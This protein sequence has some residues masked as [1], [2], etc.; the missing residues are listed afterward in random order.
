MTAPRRPCSRCGTTKPPGRGRRF[1]DDCDA[2][3]AV[4]APARAREHG[5]RRVE[6]NRAK[7]EREGTGRVYRTKN[8]PEGQAWC[9]RCQQ[10]LLIA[11][12]PTSTSRKN[13]LAPYCR[14]CYSEFLHARRLRQEFDMTPDEY[15]ELL[16]A[17]DG[18][19]AICMAMP[20]TRRLAVDHDHK[21]GEVRGLLCTRCNHKVLGAARENPSILRRAAEY[22]ERTL[23]REPVASPTSKF[24]QEVERF[25]DEHMG[26]TAGIE[27]EFKARFNASDF[28]VWTGDLE[29]RAILTGRYRWALFTRH[30]GRSV[31]EAYVTL[32]LWAFAELVGETP[33]TRAVA[34]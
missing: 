12:F 33:D 4:E 15:A 3:L 8:A 11:D 2:I 26:T 1:C 13:G 9:S 18:R 31:R 7:R 30:R 17:Q 22:L 32:P 16:A 34:S 21:T 5:K 10:Y 25:I 6:R 28:E 14:P 29:R 19:C 24:G 20:R 27:T 23:L